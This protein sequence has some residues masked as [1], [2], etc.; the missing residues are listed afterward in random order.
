M[1]SVHYQNKC[2]EAPIHFSF[3]ADLSHFNFNIR[4]WFQAEISA[5]SFILVSCWTFVFHSSISKKVLNF[6]RCLPSNIPMPIMHQ[7]YLQQRFEESYV[8]SHGIL[9]LAAGDAVAI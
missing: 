8:A 5:P 3:T 1:C 6:I 9:L 2:S 4:P 7:Y